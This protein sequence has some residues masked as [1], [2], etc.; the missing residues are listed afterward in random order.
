LNFTTG[1]H[2]AYGVGSYPWWN[3]GSGGTITIT[4]GVQF[5]GAPDIVGGS[6][7]LQGT[8]NDAKVVDF[9][10]STGFKITG[11]SFFDTKHGSLLS[12]F[13][14]APGTPFEGNFNIGF[15]A[16]MLQGG[17]FSSNEVLSGSVVN[18]VVP[19]PA[20]AWLF[21][22]GLGSLVVARFRQVRSVC[23]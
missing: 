10:G 21:G 13:G 22:T 11:A 8:F 1:A 12:Y 9:G 23:A 16:G 4:G 7:L 5:Q 6:I 19:L 3:F 15:N 17:G 14:L 2:T 18:T 20:A